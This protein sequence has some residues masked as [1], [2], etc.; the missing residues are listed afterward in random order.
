MERPLILLI[1]LTMVLAKSS[2]ELHHGQAGE[3]VLKNLTA[4]CR[5]GADFCEDPVDYPLQ[6][7]SQV[8][9]KKR[10]KREI[11]RLPRQVNLYK[12]TF[13]NVFFLK[14]FYSNL[15][16]LRGGPQSRLIDFS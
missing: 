9:E 14:A 16:P 5:Y 11:R 13:E 15:S 3:I 10:I 7:I 4:S 1:S 2:Q 8:I 12:L 6:L